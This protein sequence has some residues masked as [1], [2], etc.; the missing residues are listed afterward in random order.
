MAG[1]RSASGHFSNSNLTG[2]SAH[3]CGGGTPPVNQRAVEVLDVVVGT[4]MRQHKEVVQET[5]ESVATLVG[6]HDGLGGELSRKRHEVADAKG[7]G[8]SVSSGV[9]PSVHERGSVTM[10][11]RSD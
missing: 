2:A 8:V 6:I 5:D 4:G 1:Q 10:T 3:V 11:G 9:R 7:R